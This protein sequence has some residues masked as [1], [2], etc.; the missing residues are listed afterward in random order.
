MVVAYA[1]V[2]TM[3]Y[4]HCYIMTTGIIKPSPYSDGA[5]K[6]TSPRAIC[7]HIFGLSHNE[8]RARREGRRGCSCFGVRL[9]DLA[10]R[11]VSLARECRAKSWSIYP[12]PYSDS[13]YVEMHNWP[14]M[15][16]CNFDEPVKRTKNYWWDLRPVEEYIAPGDERAMEDT[17]KGHFDPD[18]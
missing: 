6:R 15:G 9:T 11:C 16:L 10:T 13:V 5:Y 8:R 4:T 12:I 18:A 3:C 7:T 17:T 1:T 14:E 2:G